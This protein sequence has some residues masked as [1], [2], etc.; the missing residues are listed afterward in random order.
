MS[1]DPIS[2]DAS[3][4]SLSREEL[5]AGLHVWSDEFSD[6]IESLFDQIQRLEME[7]RQ[8]RHELKTERRYAA[9]REEQL[10]EQ[11]GTLE[12]QVESL[13]ELIRSEENGPATIGRARDFVAR[14]S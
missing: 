14:P 11:V 1:N 6:F 8:N 10:Q 5:M 7:L 12:T 9:A 13:W 3:Q 2:P 4:K